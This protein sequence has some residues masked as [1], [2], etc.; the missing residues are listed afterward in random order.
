[1]FLPL[2]EVDLFG[3]YMAPA[4]V[5]LCICMVWFAVFRWIVG[6]FIDVD[7]VVWRRPLFGIA[8]FVILYSLAILTLRPV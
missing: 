6:L 4:G 1:M 2:Q 3:V 5:V 7:R 8:C